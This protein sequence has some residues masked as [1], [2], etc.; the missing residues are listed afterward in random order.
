[1]KDGTMVGNQPRL[2]VNRLVL[3]VI[4]IYMTQSLMSTLAMQ[5]VPA[6]VRSA[7]G[8][9][10]LIG[11]STLFMLPWALKF[12]WAPLTERW[13]L[14]HGKTFRRSRPMILGGQLL[15]V[16]LLLICAAMGALDH[17]HQLLKSA[18]LWL[19]MLFFSGALIASTVDIVCDGFCVDQ[20][21]ARGY[22]WGNV[23]QVGGSYIGMMAGGG[24]FLLMVDHY[25]WSIASLFLALLILLFSLP[26]WWIDEPKRLEKQCHRPSLRYAMARPETRYGL[27][28]I[29]CLNLG[30]RIVLP[31][32]GPLL[33]DHGLTMSQLGWLFGS[34]SVIAGV[35]GTVIG[36]VLIKLTG[37]WRALRIAYWVQGVMLLGI[38]ASLIFATPAWLNLLLIIGVVGQFM[39]TACS[40]V[41]AY[42]VLMSLSSPLQAGVDFTLFQ[43]A[44]AG[45]AIIS[46]VG[47]GIL[48][49]HLGYGISFGGAACFTFLGIGMSLIFQRRLERQTQTADIYG[50]EGTPVKEMT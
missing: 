3:A 21:S 22:G 41:C 19:F 14:P 42:S 29:I 43:C 5:S 34:G 23:A 50:M 16:V 45:I 9:L 32:Y 11:A 40:M 12:I 35:A 30:V 24:L 18:L 31:L 6:L 47:G 15:L 39:V 27:V 33:L 49:Q 25:G 44:D 2:P 28:L 17:E 36:G 48:A 20:L 10:T 13:R 7:G 37:L 26:L 4:G 1:M 8:S 46:G 38:S